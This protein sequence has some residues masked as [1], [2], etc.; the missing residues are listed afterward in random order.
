MTAQQL[1]VATE[2][3]IKVEE[4][5]KEVKA[6]ATTDKEVM[7]SNPLTEDNKV[8]TKLDLHLS[9][10]TADSLRDSIMEEAEDKREEVLDKINLVQFSSEI[11]AK[12]TGTRPLK[13]CKLSA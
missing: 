11:W 1:V 9:N 7:A 12:L 5:F 13:F 6:T 8:V 3:T 4:D 10:S 2:I